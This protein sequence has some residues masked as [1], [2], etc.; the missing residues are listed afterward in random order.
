MNNLDMKIDYANLLVK[1]NHLEV[2]T[3]KIFLGMT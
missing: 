1:N 3:L 2:R